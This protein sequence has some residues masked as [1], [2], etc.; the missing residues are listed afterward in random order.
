[1]NTERFVDALS[2]CNLNPTEIADI[3]WLALRQPPRE[4]EP[5]FNEDI[6]NA[7]AAGQGTVSETGSGLTD[8][9]K[10]GD[11]EE[12]GDGTP[13]EDSDNQPF[14]IASEPPAGKLPPKTLPIS[15]PDAKFLEA[16]LPIVRALRPIL[17]RVDSTTVQRMDEG[18]TADRIAETDI[19][20]PVM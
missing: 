20:S 13:Q 12:R 19:W 2:E 15:V 14:D 8:N 4:P 10:A 3:L 9:G 11:R 17:K 1:M 7:A 16:T 5:E 6:G 18:A